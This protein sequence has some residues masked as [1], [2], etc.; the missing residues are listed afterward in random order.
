MGDVETVLASDY[1]ALLE[2][3][4][5][6]VAALTEAIELMSDAATEHDGSIEDCVRCQG[7]NKAWELYRSVTK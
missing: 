2:L 1:D 5:A 7:Y 4:R 6:H 3:Y